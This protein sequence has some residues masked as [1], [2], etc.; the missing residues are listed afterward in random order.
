ME[1]IFTVS[2]AIAPSE[3]EVQR[4]LYR[5][6]ALDDEETF[7][8]QKSEIRGIEIN[9][10]LQAIDTYGLD[11]W[12][13]MS[14]FKFNFETSPVDLILLAQTKTYLIQCHNSIYR[15][16]EATMQRTRK[17]YTSL[18]EVFEKVDVD[19][20]LQDPIIVTEEAAS[21]LESI[22]ADLNPIFVNYEQ[23]K[24]V[25]ED[26]AINEKNEPM[27][28]MNT[29]E[30]VHWLAYQDGKYFF[31]PLPVEDKVLFKVEPGIQCK[32]CDSF[33]VTCHGDH[34]QCKCG[35]TEDFEET[36]VRTIREWGVINHEKRL[37]VSDLLGFLSGVIKRK[38]L[39]AIMNKYFTPVSYIRH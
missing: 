8:Y 13:V 26:I 11:S 15:T 28:K 22:A 7:E 30:I 12:K 23:F 10:A 2:Q 19:L 5:R 25:I 24:K 27:A 35:E 16:L 1:R 31:A 17:I 18:N 6:K 21:R 4:E 39:N 29:D 36:I 37:E 20:N 32:F 3:L 38:Q 34:I 9:G 33:S 14:D